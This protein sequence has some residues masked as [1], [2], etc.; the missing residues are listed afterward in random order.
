M[1]VARRRRE[2]LPPAM[3]EQTPAA[4]GAVPGSMSQASASRGVAL[5]DGGYVRSAP[6]AGAYM[7]GAASASGGK[8][9]ALQSRPPPAAAAAGGGAGSSSAGGWSRETLTVIGIAVTLLAI[10]ALAIV[11]PAPGEAGG[12][13]ASS[14]SRGGTRGR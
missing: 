8:P 1:E 9:A 10:L 2:G 12:T 13:R 11:T 5:P 14:R 7:R 6:P 3:M 4:V